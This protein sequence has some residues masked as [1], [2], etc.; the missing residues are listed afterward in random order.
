MFEQWKRALRSLRFLASEQSSPHVQ[1][2]SEACS[3]PLSPT[4]KGKDEYELAATSENHGKKNKKRKQKKDM[5][6]LK[7]EVD[8]VS[9]PKGPF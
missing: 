7:K 4:Q 1:S 2:Y 8:L 9:K 3:V 5:D 6:E